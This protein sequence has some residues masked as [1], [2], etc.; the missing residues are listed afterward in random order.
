MRNA[1]Y[2]TSPSQKRTALWLASILFGLTFNLVYFYYEA[3]LR[4]IQDVEFVVVAVEAIAVC[5][6]I[7]I[8]VSLIDF[9]FQKH[10]SLQIVLLNLIFLVIT[11]GIYL[12]RRDLLMM[13]S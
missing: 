6:I 4:T 7:T 3:I 8:L 5:Y 1:R 12:Y 9:F 11:V 13:L 10:R 2:F